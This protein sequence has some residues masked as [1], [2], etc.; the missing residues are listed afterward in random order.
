MAIFLLLAIGTFAV[1]PC[2]GIF[3]FVAKSRGFAFSGKAVAGEDCNS[4]AA[5]E[6]NLATS[7]PPSVAVSATVA[8]LR[9]STTD[10]IGDI[11]PFELERG[12][13][14]ID[15]PSKNPKEAIVISDSVLPIK[16]EPLPS[17]SLSSIL[18]DGKPSASVAAGA[19]AVIA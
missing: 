13:Y 17:G 7:S 2:A 11:R 18:K 10:S 5:T 12:M 19:S 8:R 14:P 4:L 9:R 1:S 6:L 15:R 16:I 3:T